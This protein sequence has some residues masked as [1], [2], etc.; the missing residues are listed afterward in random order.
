MP[1]RLVSLR[2]QAPH[3]RRSEY[4]ASWGRLA[5]AASAEGAHAWRFVSAERDELFLEFLEFAAD[6]DPRVDTECSAAL[7][8]LHALFPTPPPAAA[9]VE[10]WV[11]IREGV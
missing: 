8:T 11:E 6:R 9:F 2:R 1:R 4:D 3:E 10:E 5:T 7:R